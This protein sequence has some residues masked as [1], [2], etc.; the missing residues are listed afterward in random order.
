MSEGKYIEFD[1]IVKSS[2]SIKWKLRDIINFIL[3]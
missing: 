1:T 2:L 3:C